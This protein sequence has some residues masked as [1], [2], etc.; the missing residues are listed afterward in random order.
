METSNNI[1]VSAAPSKAAENTFFFNGND[2]GLAL[3]VAMKDQNE[4]QDKLAPTMSQ[5]NL[6][7]AEAAIEQLIQQTNAF[8][9][10]HELLSHLE[11]EVKGYSGNLKGFVNHCIQ[12]IQGFFNSKTYHEIEEL[13][14]TLKKLHHD[15]QRLQHLK[16]EIK[17][18]GFFEKIKAIFEIGSAA[19]QVT[20]DLTKIQYL[21]GKINGGNWSS[22]ILPAAEG[23]GPSIGG[24]MLF[25][26]IGS[27]LGSALASLESNQ[28][29]DNA[30]KE[31]KGLYSQKNLNVE[32]VMNNAGIFKNQIRTVERQM[33]QS[34][35]HVRT[36]LAD[37]KSL[38]GQIAQEAKLSSNNQ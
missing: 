11:T 19:S 34:I 18:G 21:M 3:A 29:E 20:S 5:Q 12:N 16:H 28:T 33:A 13:K 4:V 35:M 38:S 26:P 36:F 37:L 7:I 1:Q 10:L 14:A 8:D 6:M 17:H 2:Y 31:L 9:G 30:E 15:I 25:G 23:F 22:G 32:E 27:Y 24:T